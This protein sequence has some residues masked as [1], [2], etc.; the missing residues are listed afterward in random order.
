MKKTIFIFIVMI[1]SIPVFGQNNRFLISLQIS[2]PSDQIYKEWFDMSSYLE[3]NNIE[4]KSYCWGILLGYMIEDETELRINFSIM[5]NHSEGGKTSKLINF[6]LNTTTDEIQTNIS[7]AA[8]IVWTLNKNKIT[9]SA[10]F[11]FPI[12][13]YGKYTY[14]ELLKRTDPNTGTVLD[15]NQSKD[16]FPASYSFGTGAILGFKYFPFK[17]FSIGAEYSPSLLYAKLSGERT[18][19]YI[20]KIVDNLTFTDSIQYDDEGFCFFDQRFSISLDIWF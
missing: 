14:E 5:R 6:N 12:N 1:L 16:I 17:Y 20:N 15:Y 10:G 3:K 19:I 7:L 18:Q 13:F 8:G 2:N 9:F 11:E 4:H